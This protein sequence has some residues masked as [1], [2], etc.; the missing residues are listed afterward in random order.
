MTHVLSHFRR[1]SPNAVGINDRE[2]RQRVPSVT[3][4]TGSGSTKVKASVQRICHQ[5]LISLALSPVE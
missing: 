5:P 3:H 4:A 1:G 2:I